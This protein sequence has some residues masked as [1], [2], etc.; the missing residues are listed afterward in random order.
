MDPMGI[1]PALLNSNVMC[2][3][4]GENSTSTC[5]N[6]SYRSPFAH[7]GWQAEHGGSLAS[8]RRGL[9]HCDGF[10]WPFFSPVWSQDEQPS[11]SAQADGRV[12]MNS[13]ALKYPSFPKFPISINSLGMCPPL[14]AHSRKML[15]P[16]ELVWKLATTFQPL[17]SHILYFPIIK[18]Y[19]LFMLF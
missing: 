6:V 4:V 13:T 5:E 2:C 11:Q 10:W 14:V 3:H 1:G 8:W 15:F 18:W 16:Y 7:L 9:G 17:F 19:H 12:P